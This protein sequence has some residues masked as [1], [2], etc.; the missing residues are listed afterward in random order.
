MHQM[1]TMSEGGNNDESY[2]EAPYEKSHNEG[3][4]LIMFQAANHIRDSDDAE[5]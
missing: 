5:E 3:V 4:N 2:E 1:M